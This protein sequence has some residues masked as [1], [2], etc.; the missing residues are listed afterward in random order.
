[1]FEVAFSS[2]GDVVNEY[3]EEGLPVWRL[4]CCWD[5]CSFLGAVGLGAGEESTKLKGCFMRRNLRG[6]AAASAATFLVAALSGCSGLHVDAA[7]KAGKVK[8]GE[9]SSE[10]E[11]EQER[12]PHDSVK[13][14]ESRIRG[15]DENAGS[16]AGKSDERTSDDSASEKK[17]MSVGEGA[18][19][20]G[21]E[22]LWFD[23]E[24]EDPWDKYVWKSQKFIGK[25]G[26][27]PKLGPGTADKKFWGLPDL[28]SKQ[29]QRR[30]K[31]VGFEFSDRG[32]N[33]S[34]LR[35]CYWSVGSDDVM[36]LSLKTVITMYSDSPSG[37]TALKASNLDWKLTSFRPVENSRHLPDFQC[38]AQQVAFGEKFI[39]VL[40]ADMETG[41]TLREACGRSASVTQVV[42]N[43]T[44]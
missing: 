32:A 35:D 42:Q 24:P 29:M 8:M 14:R 40:V 6:T 12:Q 22:G 41:V 25:G 16:M 9:P 26:E 44:K 28:C 30:M 27:I 31:E 43:L 37:Y 23:S 3:G 36:D 38:A 19:P 5:G 7:S 33:D 34:G 2:N 4:S 17:G 21:H 10:V 39:T 18:R 11:A 15:A 13:G 1:M 20:A